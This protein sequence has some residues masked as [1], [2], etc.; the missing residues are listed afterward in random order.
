M[1]K[2]LCKQLPS[3]QAAGTYV[4]G[5]EECVNILI[6]IETKSVRVQTSQ[7]IWWETYSY[8]NQVFQI[9]SSK[10]PDNYR[11]LRQF[12]VTRILKQRPTK[13]C[14]RITYWTLPPKRTPFQARIDRWS[15]LWK[16]PTRRRISHT[17]P[18]WLW[19][20]SL[21]KISSPGPVLYGTKWLLWR[22]HK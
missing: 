11:L 18:M 10:P 1:W 15:N 14:G 19:G 12:S 6:F 8:T 3:L 5:I 9:S 2:G 22:P 16:V 20:H 21:F 17:F 7:R 13:L 4:S